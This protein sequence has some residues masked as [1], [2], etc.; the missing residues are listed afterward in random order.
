MHANNAIK[1]LEKFKQLLDIQTRL[2]G[3]EFLIREKNIDLVS[4]TREL[5]KE[6]DIRK[7]SERKE[8]H[9]RRHVYLVSNII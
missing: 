9:Q 8:E 3:R 2:G 4:Q 1:K 7:I 6:G 5:V